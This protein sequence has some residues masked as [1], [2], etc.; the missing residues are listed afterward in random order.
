MADIECPA[1]VSTSAKSMN[2]E[3]SIEDF[4]NPKL[5][6]LYFFE[7]LGPGKEPANWGVTCHYFNITEAQATPQPSSTSVAT[8]MPT[9]EKKG[10]SVRAAAGIAVGVTFAAVFGMGTIGWLLCRRRQARRA[11]I[12]GDEKHSLD[13]IQQQQYQYGQSSQWRPELPVEGHGLYEISAPSM[14]ARY[15]MASHQGMGQAGFGDD[16]PKAFTDMR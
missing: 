9:T 10:L 11:P 13:G 16:R 8:P 1:S 14:N 12:T 4:P 6:N 3:V 5:S 2:W 15:E 7:L